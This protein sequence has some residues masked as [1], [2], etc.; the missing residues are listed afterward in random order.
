MEER[1]EIDP[2]II[3]SHNEQKQRYEK[4]YQNFKDSSQG[5]HFASDYSQMI[6]F[7]QFLK[8][9]K[10]EGKKILDLGCGLGDFFKFLD[11]QGIKTKYTGYDIVSDF[12][13]HCQKTYQDAKFEERDILFSRPK[14]KFEY[15]FA[16]G[17][18]AHGN[19]MFFEEMIKLA[20]DLSKTAFAFNMYEAKQDDFFQISKEEVL[21]LCRRLSPNKIVLIEDYLP[22]DYTIFL[23][24]I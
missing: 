1:L 6:R 16:S 11:E 4:L 12:I 19:K 2:L 5:L 17:I 15:V 7:L 18:F 13:F 20:F 3:Q 8:I 22:G 14:E 24:K 21:F 23:Y 10:I 9:G